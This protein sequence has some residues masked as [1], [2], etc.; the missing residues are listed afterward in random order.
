MTIGSLLQVEAKG[1]EELALYGN[2][3]ISYFQQVFRR[4]TN[5]AVDF[6]KI[7][8]NYLSRADFGST[9]KIKIPHRGDLL[10][11]LYLK[12]VFSDLTKLNTNDPV[13]AT[14]YVNGIGYNFIEEIK[15]YIN[16]ICI[17]TLN[18]ELIFLMNELLNSES[19][20]KSFY[21]ITRFYTNE[22]I[23][24]ATNTKDVS[25]YLFIPFFFSRDP[26]VFLPICALQNSE[27]VVEIRLKQKEKCLIRGYDISN[28]LISEP[29][30][31]KIETLELFSKSIFLE[32]ME[33]NYFQTQELKYL[34]ELFNIGEVEKL[35]TPMDRTNYYVPLNLYHPTKYIFWVLQR[36]DVYEANFYENYT[37][38]FDLK[39]NAFHDYEFDYNNH[40]LNDAVPLVNNT[41]LTPVNDAVFMSSVQLYDN[42]K[43]FSDYNIYISNY[44]LNPVSSNPTGTFNFSKILNKALR[45]SLVDSSKYTN[46]SI[47]ANII[48]RTYSC[49]YNFLMIKNGL[50]GLMYS[51]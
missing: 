33:K 27:L 49:N 19:R 51:K 28:N 30:N 18:A 38:G 22:F 47:K 24:G 43:T 12:T 50:G 48:L 2:P 23:I 16:G 26:S 17:E 5:F 11:G 36:D 39:Y 41:E 46:N 34:I 40:L 10:G 9:I 4:S 35:D 8:D 25:T 7:P 3:Q 32:N 14:S 45:L 44:A 13:V 37:Y 31:A 1:P 6:F 42:F 21:R 15:F 29:V 20:K